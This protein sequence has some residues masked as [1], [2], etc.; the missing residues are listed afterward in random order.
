MAN[1]NH[2]GTVKD[3]DLKVI[4]RA[5]HPLHGRDRPATVRVRLDEVAP[6]SVHWEAVPKSIGF[7]PEV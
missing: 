7:S 1:P 3:T 5:D 2:F 4:V 6:T